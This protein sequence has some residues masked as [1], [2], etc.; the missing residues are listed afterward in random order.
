MT[1]LISKEVVFNDNPDEIFNFQY[2]V[3]TFFNYSN[4][5]FIIITFARCI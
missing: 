4:R 3:N 5:H 1:D 2:L